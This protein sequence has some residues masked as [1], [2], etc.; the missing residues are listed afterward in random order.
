M[1]VGLKHVFTMIFF[2]FPSPSSICTHTQTFYLLSSCSK[3]TK[4]EG[5]R[6]SS[7]C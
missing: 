7:R 5:H 4:S 2:H 1:A 6:L 3:A